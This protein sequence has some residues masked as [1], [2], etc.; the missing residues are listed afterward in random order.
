MKKIIYSILLLGLS[1]AM[2]TSCGNDDDDSQRYSQTPAKD[3]AG[4][5]TGVLTSSY[6][7]PTTKEKKVNTKDVTAT[8]TEDEESPYIVSVQI[9]STDGSVNLTSK[10]N[11][12]ATSSYYAFSNK[13]AKNGIGFSFSGDVTGNVFTLTY[14]G[15][16]AIMVNRKPTMIKT[17]Y[18][19]TG[20]R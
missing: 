6:T 3:T 7:D 17:T 4:E 19:I 12:F 10:A 8:L 1:V 5:Y 9:T 15:T 18:V 20:S 16:T 14:E 2:V 13:E 11:I